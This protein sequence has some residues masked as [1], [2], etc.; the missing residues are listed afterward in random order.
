MR[1]TP[2][3]EMN[4]TISNLTGSR[5]PCADGQ[6]N[7]HI[8]AN[9]GVTEVSDL[10]Q[11]TPLRV[12]FPRVETEELF[13][14]VLVNSS[15]GVVGGDR[16]EM[17]LEAGHG[18]SLLVTGQAAEKV[19]RSAGEEANA[20]TT[21]TAQADSFIEFLPQGTIIF[22]GARFRRTTIIDASTGSRVMAGEVLTLGRVARNER[23]TGGSFH[24]EWRVL[25][26]GRLVWVDALHLSD[27]L[28]D[29]TESVLASP[30]G[31]AKSPGYATFIYTADDADSHVQ[32]AR[33]IQADTPGNVQRGVTSF[34]GVLVA[35]WLGP[36]P[37]D[38]RAA[39]GHFWARFRAKVCGLPEQLPTIWN[40]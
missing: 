40:I 36:K 6:L 19:Y 4:A 27:D 31:F 1:D 29:G 25:R 38:V 20:S 9:G 17:K 35:R 23:F 39:Y 22:D 5:R 10:Y 16:L 12:L 8:I 28:E 34:D 33:T 24:D 14:A 26:N 11:Q 37:S 13:T 2:A 3:L 18:A 32:L 7:L 30:A 21:L 15:G